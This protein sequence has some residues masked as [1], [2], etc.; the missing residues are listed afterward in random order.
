MT[1]VRLALRWRELVARAYYTITSR[2]P[3]CWRKLAACAQFKIQNSLTTPTSPT[4]PK[5][6]TSPIRPTNSKFKIQNSSHRTFS[7]G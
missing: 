2:L 7:E 6:L 5:S 1:P 4:R 3:S